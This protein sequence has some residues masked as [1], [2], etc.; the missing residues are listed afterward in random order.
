VV[1]RWVG[2]MGRGG[3]KEGRRSRGGEG[4]AAGI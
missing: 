4:R 2:F 3:W 1:M